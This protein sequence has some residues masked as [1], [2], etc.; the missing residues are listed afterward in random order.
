MNQSAPLSPIVIPTPFDAHV[1]LRDGE[2]L[3][4][5]ALHIAS[6]FGYGIVM[7]NLKPPVT[8]VSQALEYRERILAHVPEI[9]PFTPFMTLYL[10]DSTLTDD[11]VEIT[12]S[13]GAVVACK[14][15]PANAT[16]NS[17]D[18]VTDIE[19]AYGILEVMERY[20]VPLCV[21]GEVTDPKIDVFDREKVFLDQKLRR[22]VETFP[23]LPVV[24]EHVTTAEGVQFVENYGPK[25]AASITAHHLLAN[26]NAIFQNG[27]Q[28]H[29]YCL[30]V[31]KREEHR[32]ELLRAATSGSNKFFAG[33]DSAPHAKGL[34]ETSC[35][36]AGCYTAPQSIEMYAAAF[37]EAGAF[38]AGDGG[39]GI[40]NFTQF[41][42]VAGPLFYK[43][44]FASGY[45]SLRRE[46]YAVPAEYPFTGAGPVIPF[47]A[48][49]TL[50]WKSERVL[51][52]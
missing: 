11:I 27:L 17:Q 40:A 50:Q 29:A 38:G 3:A 15:Y 48:G 20:G 14:L 45:V 52:P 31:L 41:L 6:R 23:A 8:K 39:K 36:C 26:R 21:H 19:A 2:A 9:F 51:K 46:E 7:P 1:H 13:N 18:G 35:G 42:S 44:P 22:I 25:V 12:R 43:I 10:T 28:P 34:K 33:T 16:T 32:Q 4:T 37:E 30:P 5:T 49:K 24:L 47:L